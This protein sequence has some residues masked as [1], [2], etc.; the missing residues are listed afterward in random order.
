MD[1]ILFNKRLNFRSEP[2]FQNRHSGANTHKSSRFLMNS[3]LAET[4]AHG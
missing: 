1:A 2:S 3:T 4:S